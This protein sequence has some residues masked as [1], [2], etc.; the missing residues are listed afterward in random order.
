M[1]E[2]DLVVIGAGLAG[3]TA[4]MFGARHGLHTVVVDQMGA[5]GQIIN[6][7]RVEDFP[8]FP[9][10]IPGYDLGP[11]VQ[12]QAE[13]AGAEFVLDT[14]TGLRLDGAN[15]IVSCDA[16]DELQ[17]RAVIIACGSSFRR[18]GIPG[19]EQFTGRGVSTCATCDG[20]FFIGEPVGVIGGGDSALDEALVLAQFGS[21]VTVF[22]RGAEV[23]G[24][25]V[26]RKRIAESPKIE[27][28]LNATVE[29]IVGDEAVSGVRVVTNGS[30]SEHAVRGVFVY[31]GLEPNTAFLRDVVELD[32]AGHIVTDLMMQTSVPGVFAAGDLRQHSV[33]Q[34]VSAAGDG[35]TAAV[36]AY[37]YVK[38]FTA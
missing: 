28:V 1:R 38:S 13:A 36:A 37:R 10:G 25:Q 21:S 12:E 2:Y 23:D 31:V 11:L 32:P 22:H 15:R 20:P 24:Q 8:G 5:G 33:R 6:A 17:A 16:E 18:L 4:A 35:A 27:V 19:E 9:E 7:E 34:L 3:L 14:A 29:A 26:F 30:V